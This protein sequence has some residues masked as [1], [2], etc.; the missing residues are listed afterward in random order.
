MVYEHAFGTNPRYF[1]CKHPKDITVAAT[2]GTPSFL[3]TFSMEWVGNHAPPNRGLPYWITTCKQLCNEGL[4]VFMRTRIFTPLYLGYDHH[5]RRA[6]AKDN[7]LL[8]TSHKIRN[9][10]I[11]QSYRVK[12]ADPTIYGYDHG[13]ITVVSVSRDAN[14]GIQAFLSYI[15]QRQLREL[16]LEFR[17]D[18]FWHG[19]GGSTCKDWLNSEGKAFD[20][21]D[22]TWNGTFRQLKLTIVYHSKTETTWSDWWNWLRSVPEG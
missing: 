2:L 22:S 6:R 3:D 21:L 18:R 4:P 9:I 11:S 20:F 15:R 19:K 16:T 7:S 10:A 1:C 13:L 14:P 17:W 12:Y 5:Y 8:F